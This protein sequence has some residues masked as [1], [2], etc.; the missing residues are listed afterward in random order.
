VLVCNVLH[1]AL[2]L[3]CTSSLKWHGHGSARVMFM[4]LPLAFLHLTFRAI[5]SDFQSLNL[6]NHYLRADGA[7]ALRTHLA[8]LGKVRMTL[9]K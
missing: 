7:A 9:T 5:F 6:S 1:L 8:K 2:F 3:P 4:K